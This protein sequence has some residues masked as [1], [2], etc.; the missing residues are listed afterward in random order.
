MTAGTICDVLLIGAVLTC[1]IGSVG[2]VRMREP[3]QAL[4][5]LS[6]PATLGGLLLAA[7]VWVERG[8]TSASAKVTAI[9]VLLILVNSVVTHAAARMF[10]VR[11]AGDW[12]SGKGVHT[13]NVKDTK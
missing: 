1:W 5:Y 11:D 6:A 2:M 12:R 7:A 10:R 4:H 13:E 9:A 8:A 3:I